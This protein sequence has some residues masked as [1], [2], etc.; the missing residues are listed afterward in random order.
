MAGTSKSSVTWHLA[1]WR[2]IPTDD[3]A[4]EAERPDGRQRGLD[5]ESAASAEEGRINYR[6]VVVRVCVPAGAE[7]EASRLHSMR[8]RGSS[9]SRSSLHGRGARSARLTEPAKR[10]LRCVQ[11]SCLSAC[12]PATDIDKLSELRLSRRF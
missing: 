6:R 8:P 7:V 10:S 5:T 1:G 4:T 2:R 9:Q 11:A 3:H 12:L